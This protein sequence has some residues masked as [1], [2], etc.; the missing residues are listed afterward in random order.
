MTFGAAGARARVHDLKDVI[1]IFDIFQSHGHSEVSYRSIR[2]G[3]EL[4]SFVC[5]F[6]V[7]TARYY[8]EGT[9]EAYLG[10]VSHVQRVSV[11]GTGDITPLKRGFTIIAELAS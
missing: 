6:Q 2:Q 10:D 7:D 1:T 9:S 5:Y 8:C 11:S 3:F 4:D